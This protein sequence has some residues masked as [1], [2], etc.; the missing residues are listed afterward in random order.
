MAQA[1]GKGKLLCTL[2]HLSQVQLVKQRVDF[3]GAVQSA[4]TAAAAVQIVRLRQKPLEAWGFQCRCR[5][6]AGLCSSRTFLS[7]S[8]NSAVV[9]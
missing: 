8:C 9:R 6:R 7:S 3:P 5:L 1:A 4:T 2:R